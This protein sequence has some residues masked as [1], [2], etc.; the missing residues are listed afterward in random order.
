M[1]SIGTLDTYHYRVIAVGIDFQ[2]SKPSKEIK[3]F[4]PG[5]P[6]VPKPHLKTIRS[7]NGVVSLSFKA[8]GD[9]SLTE[10]MLVIRGNSVEDPG[11]I[12]GKRLSGSENG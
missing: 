2:N 3:V 10:Q 6:E 5:H 9:A 11:L 12:I 4:L 7:E 1:F 8:A